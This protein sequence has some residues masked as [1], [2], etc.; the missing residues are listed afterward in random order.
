MTQHVRSWIDDFVRRYAEKMPHKSYL[1]LPACFTKTQLALLCRKDVCF[2]SKDETFKRPSTRLF[3]SVWAEHF[4][5]VTIPRLSDFAACNTCAKLKQRGLLKNLSPEAKQKLDEDHDRKTHFCNTSSFQKD[6]HLLILHL[7]HMGDSLAPRVNVSC[8][9]ASSHA[10]R[11]HIHSRR[12]CFNSCHDVRSS[13]S[14][15]E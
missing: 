13:H 6:F 1:H 2:K 8:L 9:V 5:H 12:E 7:E 15:R 10:V 3:L 14:R 4:H 11:P